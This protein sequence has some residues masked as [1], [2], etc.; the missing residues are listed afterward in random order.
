M[1]ATCLG[2]KGKHG[3]RPFMPAKGI[4]PIRGRQSNVE[5]HSLLLYGTER[6]IYWVDKLKAPQQKW[7]NHSDPFWGHT[8][9]WKDTQHPRGEICGPLFNHPYYLNTPRRQYNNFVIKFTAADKKA[10]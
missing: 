5:V 7:S 8:V 2:P 1:V 9:L 3:L 10:N 4:L 6:Q